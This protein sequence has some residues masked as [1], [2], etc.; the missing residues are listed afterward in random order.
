VGNT[1]DGEGDGVSVS[2]LLGNDVAVPGF[3]FSI[4]EVA[5]GAMVKV[6]VTVE[7]GNSGGLVGVTD[8]CAELQ[9]CNNKNTIIGDQ[10]LY[11]I[12]LFTMFLLLGQRMP[13][14]VFFPELI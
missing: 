8:W 10:M 13:F 5:D 4:I 1:G 3:E 11:L 2:I 7:L 9:L 6:D 12:N 14:I